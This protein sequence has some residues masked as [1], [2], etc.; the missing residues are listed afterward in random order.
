MLDAAVERDPHQFDRLADLRGVVDGPTILRPD[1]HVA[2][3]AVE[4]GM[5]QPLDHPAVTATIG[6]LPQP[7][8]ILSHHIRMAVVVLTRHEQQPF[9]IG[10][11]ARREVERVSGLDPPLVTAVGP[12]NMYLVVLVIADQ[13]AIRRCGVAIGK[14]FPCSGDVPLVTAVAVHH[15]GLGDTVD[16]GSE[17]V[18]AA[19]WKEEQARVV[20]ADAIHGGEIGDRA[21]RQIEQAGIDQPAFGH[22]ERAMLAFPIAILR[23]FPQGYDDGLV[24]V[25][26]PAGELRPG[27]FCTDEILGQHPPSRPIRPHDAGA[28]GHPVRELT[29]GKVVAS[30]GV[31]DEGH[32]LVGTARRGDPAEQNANKPHGSEPWRAAATSKRD[33]HR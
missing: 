12:G 17:A 30:F 16:R 10:R 33:G 8:S 15:V 22:A 31:A 28:V 7:A 14:A 11:P 23:A 19:I 4:V 24:A 18:A 32:W 26:R 1:G 3:L 27:V 25:G 29:L 13:R 9:A 6:Q 5:L 2:A 21:R 20:D